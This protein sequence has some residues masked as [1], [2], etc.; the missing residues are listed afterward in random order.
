MP[1]FWNF[2]GGLFLGLLVGAAAGLLM[3]PKPG[4]ELRKELQQEIDDILNEARKAAELRRQ[5]LEDEFSRLR[6]DDPK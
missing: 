3:A 2:V 5:E 6:G 4:S 1:K